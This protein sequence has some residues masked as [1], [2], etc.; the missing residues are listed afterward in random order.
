MGKIEMMIC[1]DFHGKMGI[2]G[3]MR[4]VFFIIDVSNIFKYSEMNKVSI[5]R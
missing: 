5:Y 3:D 1:D 4:S 2:T